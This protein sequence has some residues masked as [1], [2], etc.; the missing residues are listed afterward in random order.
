M[1]EVF[2]AQ[3]TRAGHPRGERGPAATEVTRD[4]GAA[5]GF[6]FFTE[7]NPLLALGSAIALGLLLQQFA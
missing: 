3:R 6:V 2:S 7:R 4:G 5:A 1:R